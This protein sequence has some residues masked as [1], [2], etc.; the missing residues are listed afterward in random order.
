MFDNALPDHLFGEFSERP[1][2]DGSSEVLR[3]FT[4]ESIKLRDLFGRVFSTLAVVRIVGEDDIHDKI[5]QGVLISFGFDGMES[6]LVGVPS[7]PP[8][9]D[10]IEVQRDLLCDF[11]IALPFGGEQDNFR[12][13]DELL[14]GLSPLDNANENL[15]LNIG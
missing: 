10:G 12:S 11:D 13:S 4:G 15:M 5:F 6:F 1:M 7:E 3:V 8:G 9:S 2:G 14:C